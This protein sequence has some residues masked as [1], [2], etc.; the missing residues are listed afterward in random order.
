MCRFADMEQRHPTGMLSNIQG[1]RR[2]IY[3][4]WPPMLFCAQR[5]HQRYW[6]VYH[7]IIFVFTFPFLLVASLSR[8]MVFKAT[9]PLGMGAR[10]ETQFRSCSFLVVCHRILA[11]A[12]HSLESG[13]VDESSFEST[14]AW[15]DDLSSVFM[16]QVYVARVGV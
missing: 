1:L 14:R 7:C 4:G 10:P 13:T 3:P 12:L 15:R 8:R 6:C 9:L 2:S 16:T 11:P 5:P